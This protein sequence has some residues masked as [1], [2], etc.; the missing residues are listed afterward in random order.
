MKKILFLI[1]VLMLSFSL[2]AQNEITIGLIMPEEE[3]NGIKPDAYKLLQTKLEK[4]LTTSGVSSYGGDFVMY[5]TVNIVEEN[6]IE[7]GIKNFFKVK[8]ELNLNIV[9]LS[10]STLFSSESW[11][12]T[13]T[14]ERWR[15]DAVRNAF[16]QL[17][18]TDPR[19]KAFVD[20]TKKKICEYYETNKAAILSKASTLASTGEYEEALAVLSVYPSQVSGYNEAQELMQKIYLQYVNANAARIMNEARAAYAIKDYANAVELAAQIPSESSY[21]KEAKTI[22]DQIRATV[23]KEQDEANA[24]A[25]KALEM[26]ADVEKTRINAA[27]SV[28]RAYYGRTVVNYNVVRIY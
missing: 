9:N 18:G 14:A 13:G 7:G 1:V 20:V 22:I 25:M 3:L 8:I 11:P 5:P 26:A 19:F 10:S 23:N 12:L 17:K 2:R 21:Y 16:T 6:L 27:A 15:S 28:A 24:R 4:M